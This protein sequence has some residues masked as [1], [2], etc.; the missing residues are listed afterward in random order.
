[1][2]IKVDESKDRCGKTCDEA[3]FAYLPCARPCDHK[4]RHK[5]SA[6]LGHGPLRLPF[7]ITIRWGSKTYGMHCSG[8]DDRDC[9]NEGVR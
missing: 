2:P 8:C 4:G 5:A 6:R 1:M 7:E 3:Q 9:D